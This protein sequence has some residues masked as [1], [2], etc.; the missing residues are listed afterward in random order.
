[1]KYIRFY[2]KFLIHFLFAHHT[3]GYGVHSPYLFQFLQNV[4]YDKSSYYI[5]P[6]IETIRRDLVNDKQIL[7]VNDFG[8]GNDREL[9]ISKI[10]KNSLKS[11]KYGQ[12]LFKA[13]NF[14]K[15]K[16]VLELGTSL[17]LTTSYLA[18]SSTNIRCI[19]LEG[20]TE[21]AKVACENFKILQLE[22][23]RIITGNID[24][25]LREVLNEFENLDLIFIDANHKLPEIYQYFEL[26]LAKV[27]DDTILVIDDIY[28]SADMEKTW[29]MIKSHER[30]TS[31]FDFFQL[32]IVFF[33]PD[34]YKAHY[35]MRY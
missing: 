1:M 7:Y 34:L 11:P 13:V 10:A 33:R 28:W 22:N 9:T 14:S 35:R 3:R 5:F 4:I 25:T 31:T 29:S 20:S 30:V 18:S 12:M 24:Y 15:S 6:K 2:Y 26:C 23:I 32:G 16:N 27:H 8:T 21:I 19:S 17:G